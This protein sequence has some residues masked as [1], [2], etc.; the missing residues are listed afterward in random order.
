MNMSTIKVEQESAAW[1]SN[2]YQASHLALLFFCFFY[3]L[4]IFIQSSLKSAD[5]ITMI[6]NIKQIEF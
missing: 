2:H 5:K 3:L 1:I 4:R 6:Y